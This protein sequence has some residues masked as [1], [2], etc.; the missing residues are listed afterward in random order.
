MLG[1]PRTLHSFFYILVL[2][3]MFNEMDELALQH[4]FFFM[5]LMMNLHYTF[6]DEF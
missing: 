4:V 2:L 5:E 6:D 1:Q 3:D